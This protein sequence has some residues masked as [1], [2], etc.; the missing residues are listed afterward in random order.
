MRLSSFVAALAIATLATTAAAHS[1]KHHHVVAPG[2]VRFTPPSEDAIEL[3]G[4]APPSRLGTIE[5][6]YGDAAVAR[7][8]FQRR[9]SAEEAYDQAQAV[10]QGTPYPC[11]PRVATSDA[12]VCRNDPHVRGYGQGYAF[13][14][15]YVSSPAVVG[16]DPSAQPSVMP[17]ITG[18][19]WNVNS[20][21]FDP[22]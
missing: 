16:E 8:H 5:Q 12:Y 14:P 18:F 11:D 1:R 2:A 13:T 22:H 9:Y 20:A 4:I 7:S 6:T 19:F 21:R 3:A 17:S 10:T 15:S